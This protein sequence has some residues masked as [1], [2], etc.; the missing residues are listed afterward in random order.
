LLF[1]SIINTSNY[2]KNRIHH[3]NFR[4]SPVYGVWK[5]YR[6]ILLDKSYCWRQTQ[7]VTVHDGADHKIFQRWWNDHR[8]IVQVQ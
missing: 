8:H 5:C 2:T 3:C 4:K 7:F 6:M 1:G